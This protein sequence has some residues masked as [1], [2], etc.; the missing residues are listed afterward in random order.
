MR[1]HYEKPDRPITYV[2]KKDFWDPEQSG[3]MVR[4]GAVVRIKPRSPK[5]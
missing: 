4:L 1:K 3:V 2:S 5:K